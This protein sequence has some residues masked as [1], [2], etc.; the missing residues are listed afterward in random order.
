M[1]QSMSAKHPS[2]YQWGTNRR[3]QALTFLILKVLSATDMAKKKDKGDAEMKDGG[4]EKEGAESK[5]KKEDAAAAKPASKMVLE[6]PP[7]NFKDLLKEVCF[8][9]LLDMALLGKD[10]SNTDRVCGSMY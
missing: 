2:K 6:A 4:E 5:K 1:A 7:S 10:H 3:F 9:S 8:L